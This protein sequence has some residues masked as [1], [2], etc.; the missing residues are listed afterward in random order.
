MKL[1]YYWLIHKFRKAFGKC[2]S[3]DMN[4]IV[5]LLL[6]KIMIQSGGATCDIPIFGNLLSTVGKK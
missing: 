6:S 3:A 4:M 5:L 2:S 1:N